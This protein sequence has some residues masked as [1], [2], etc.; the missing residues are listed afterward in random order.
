ML[1]FNKVNFSY[2]SHRVLHDCSFAVSNGELV[3]MVG[4]SGC[5]KSTLLQLCYFN[6]FPDDGE[7]VVAGFSSAS[8]SEKII[9][10][11]RRKLGIVFQDFKLLSDRT[12]FDNLAYILE[13]NNYPAKKRRGR[14]EEV[15]RDLGI[16]HLKNSYPQ[17]LSGGEQQR[18]AIGRA[19][20]NEPL[21]VIADEPT[22]N[23][24]PQTSEEIVSIF[25]DIS[26]KGTAVLLATHNYDIIDPSAKILRIEDGKVSPVRIKK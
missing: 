21:L 18:T 4:K 1:Q 3:Y 24:D 16:L 10:A 6:L 8:A 15:L 2:S 7:V 9:P 19:I 14:V 26:L 17:T 5:G 20:V 11:L 22:G 12:V 23:L 13:I 25:K